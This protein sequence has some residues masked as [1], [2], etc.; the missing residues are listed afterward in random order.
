MEGGERER[1]QGADADGDLHCEHAEQQVC[2]DTRPWRYGGRRAHTSP[3]D[4]EEVNLFV[5][6]SQIAQLECPRSG[7]WEPKTSGVAS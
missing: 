7:I 3:D 1:E 6:H 2:A 4:G 5:D